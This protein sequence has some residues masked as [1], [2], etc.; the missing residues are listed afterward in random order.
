VIISNYL[1]KVL[2]EVAFTPLTYF[3]VGFL[4]KQEGV[5]TYDYQTNFTPFNL[6]DTEYQA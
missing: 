5:D 6:K 4:K 2:V 3:I 1:L